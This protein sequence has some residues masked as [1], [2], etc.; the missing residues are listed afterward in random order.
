MNRTLSYKALILL[1]IL[2]IIGSCSTDKN[3]INI[4][5]G[6]HYQADEQLYREF[7]HQTGIRV[8]LIKAD[9]DQLINRMELEGSNSPAD[10]FITADAGRMIQAM[11]KGLLQPMNMEKI[12][13]LVPSPLRDSENHWI[14]FTKR[15]RVI[16]Y[17][18]SRVNPEELSTYEELT[19]DNWKGRIL[20]RSS[21]NHYNQTLMAS[22][23]AT[24]GR[25]GAA[26][27]ANGIVNNMAQPPRGND[28]DQVKAIAAGTGDVAIVNTYYIG[29]LL[30][31]PNAEERNIAQ[32]IGIFFPNQQN[33]GTHINI[34]AIGITAYAPN[35]EN[36]QKLIEFLLS[37]SSQST[38]AEKNYEYPAN[39]HVE[40]PDLLKEW[41]HFKADT[42]PLDQLGKHLQQGMIIF[43]QAGW[44]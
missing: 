34:S 40:L 41:G 31:S 38:L 43:N 42:T 28:R 6:R 8:N 33:R 29:L 13:K 44:N 19:S 24:H 32:R 35:A 26:K 18:K 12:A 3:E 39:Q 30:N 1:I 2:A 23:V 20:I 5:S 21:Q 4:Y 7:T 9:T 15:A 10:L 25:E 17:E 37:E 22:I 14:G 16:V 11:E 27:W 36:A